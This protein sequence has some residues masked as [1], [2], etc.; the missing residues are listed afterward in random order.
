MSDL[1]D[2][3]YVNA[4]YNSESKNEKEED[5]KEKQPKSISNRQPRRHQGKTT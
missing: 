1:S 3:E 4:Q 5:T 2:E